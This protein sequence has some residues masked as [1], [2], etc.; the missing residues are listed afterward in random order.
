MVYSNDQ[1]TPP[2]PSVVD[3][4]DSSESNYRLH[5]ARYVVVA[6]LTVSLHLCHSNRV[7]KYNVCLLPYKPTAV[8]VGLA[9]RDL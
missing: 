3:R 5:I 9:S 8:R 4:S 2:L 1:A 6:C 7:R